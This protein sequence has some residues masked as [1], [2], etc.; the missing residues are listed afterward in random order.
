MSRQTKYNRSM[1]LAENIYLDVVQIIL[2]L[3]IINI[4]FTLAD[5][6]KTVHFLSGRILISFR[7]EETGL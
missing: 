6:F 4:V 7:L 1:R 2:T 5:A 3:Q